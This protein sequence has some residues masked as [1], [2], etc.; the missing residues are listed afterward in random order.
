VG[1]GAPPA[2]FAVARAGAAL[3]L[4]ALAF[5]AAL[6]LVPLFALWLLR[7]AGPARGALGAAAALLSI[8]PA[9]V[10][11]ALATGELIPISAHAGLELAEGNDP[12]SV[13][14]YTPL[15]G[16][17]TSTLEQ[18]GDA[19]ALFARETGRR[20]SFSEVDAFFRARVFAW[21]RARPLDAAALFA[22]KLHWTLASSGYDN[23]TTFSL[24][25]EHGIGRLAELAPV[26]LPWLLG[27]AALG[28]L[29]ALRER[30]GGAPELALLALPLF[31]CVVFQ[32]SGRYRIVAAPVACGLAG[33]ALVR[34]REL[35]G[36][37]AALLAV[38]ALPL[39]ILAWDAATGFGSLDFMRADFARTLARQ[40]ARAGR[41]RE[42]EGDLA[43]ARREYARALAARPG[44]PLA[45]R[46]LY[47]LEVARGDCAAAR[48]ALEALVSA[49]PDDAEARLAL[50]WLLAAAPDPR[51]RDGAE[52][53][54][55]VDAAA[56]ALG[57]DA[58]DVLLARAL[59]LAEAGRRDDA[60]SATR[61]GEEAARARGEE[62]A[63]RS[64]ASL[65]AALGSGRGVDTPPR[66]LRIAAR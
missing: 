39:A 41:L 63:A 7:R 2:T 9:T 10:A 42:A 55:Q 4:F 31:V 49:T 58:A 13:G 28:A 45:S 66:P 40:H 6:L 5:P 8:A 15:A 26:E 43:G 50:A 36:P 35:P 32:Y 59:A 47:N 23:V 37:R 17:R 25:R 51:V 61:R 21:W 19:A 56:R 53:L 60:L 62:A 38:A 52:A 20:G 57:P 14:I 48:D 44:E 64:F 18:H 12:A 46:A 3:G 24:E 54:A 65:R 11:N 29:L 22:Q 30:R 33:A 1:P 27:L 16:I 34:W